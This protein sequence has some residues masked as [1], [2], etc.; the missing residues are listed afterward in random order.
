MRTTPRAFGPSLAPR[1]GRTRSPALAAPDRWRP[2]ALGIPTR[3]GS[4]DERGR[5]WSKRPGAAQG[6]RERGPGPIHLR[7]RPSGASPGRPGRL[8]LGSPPG[9]SPIRPVPPQP[10]THPLPLRAGQE[11]LVLTQ[12]CP[13]PTPGAPDYISHKA[14]GMRRRSEC[15]GASPR[16][17]GAPSTVRPWWLLAAL[18]HVREILF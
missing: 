1:G 7:P 4:R 15:A 10:R 13:A 11:Q 17:G 6:R 12:S 9:A 14:A 8:L 16:E 3:P 5:T 18:S 2:S